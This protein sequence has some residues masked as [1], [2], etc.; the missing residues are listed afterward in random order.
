MRMRSRGTC[1]R[2]PSTGVPRDA[3]RT[4]PTSVMISDPSAALHA[5][6]SSLFRSSSS[7]ANTASIERMSWTST[8]IA[9]PYGEGPV[10]RTLSQSVGFPYLNRNGRRDRV[11]KL[12]KAKA[13]PRGTC[14][15]RAATRTASSIA[16]R[17]VGL[18]PTPPRSRGPC[19]E[20]GVRGP[21]PAA[22]RTGP[23]CRAPRHRR[24]RRR[25]GCRACFPECRVRRRTRDRRRQA[26]ER[27]QAPLPTI[28]S[29]RAARS[30]RFGALLASGGVCETYDHAPGAYIERGVGQG[31]DLAV[32][33]GESPLAP[34]PSSPCPDRIAVLHPPGGGTCSAGVRS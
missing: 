11:P 12:L 9:I 2:R 26:A 3:T 29:A 34:E 27:N 15:A 5:A 7:S 28:P 24:S 33:A 20:E 25:G 31:G 30:R 19:H 21:A 32:L 8:A 14:L 13:G 16:R 22:H 23:S 17:T 1:N 4:N 18:S 10:A 6:T